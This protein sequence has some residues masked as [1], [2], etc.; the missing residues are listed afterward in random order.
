MIGQW[1]VSKI[2]VDHRLK[3]ANVNRGPRMKKPKSD[4]WFAV[5]GTSTETNYGFYYS[6]ANSPLLFWTVNR[7]MFV[8]HVWRVA[9]RIGSRAEHWI[10]Q[11]RYVME[12]S[13]ISGWHPCNPL[14]HYT[15]AGLVVLTFVLTAGISTFAAQCSV[16]DSGQNPQFQ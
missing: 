16:S 11:L 9:P 4:D 2:G 1:V 7:R 10:R 12:K 3:H 8:P 6:R 14:N 13:K 15:K 5:E